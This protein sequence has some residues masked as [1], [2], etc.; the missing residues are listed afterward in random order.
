MNVGGPLI[1]YFQ[2]QLSLLS[3]FTCES[4][5][6]DY[7]KQ[8]VFSRCANHQKRQSRLRGGRMRDSLRGF[9]GWV[10]RNESA[11][12]QLLTIEKEVKNE[13]ALPAS[14]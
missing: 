12:V 4:F 14:P 6:L 5:Y 3:T 8:R 10:K 9:T 2:E 7:Q 11:I 13:L 1:R